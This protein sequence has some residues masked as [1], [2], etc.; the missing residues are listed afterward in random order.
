[1]NNSSPGRSFGFT[2]IEII[3]VL[4]LVVILSTIVA[5]NVPAI[6]RLRDQPPIQRVLVD[7]V[8]EARFQA[9]VTKEVSWLSYDAEK[10]IFHV[11]LES[12]EPVPPV[13]DNSLGRF[14]S[15]VMT[16]SGD[17][18]EKNPIPPSAIKSYQ[19]YFPEDGEVPTVEFFAIPPGMGYDG[20][21]EDEPEDIPLSRVPFDPA[22][23]SVPFMVKV[24]DPNADIRDAF[25]TFDP[26]SNHVLASEGFEPR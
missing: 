14:G 4:G 6:I 3:L 18:E 1:M 20:D 2:L 13:P 17:E 16:A 22:G 24:K 25:M 23:F 21:A 5:Y 26:F 11:S 7:A 12:K 10:G 9:A 15:S 19:V 8:R